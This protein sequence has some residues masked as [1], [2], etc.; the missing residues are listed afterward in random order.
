MAG[1]PRHSQCRRTS[2]R[3]GRWAGAAGPP[4]PTAGGD[5][6]EVPDVSADADPSSG[7]I[8]YD[9]VDLDD[10]GWTALGG[11]SGAAP[12]WA[13][14]LAVVASANGN[15]AGYGPLNPALYLLAQQSPG[16]LPQRRDGG[17]QR[18][19]RHVRRAVSRHARLRHGHRAGYAGGVGAGDRPRRLAAERGRLG[20]PDLRRIADLHRCRRFPRDRARCLSASR[21]TAAASTAP[22]W[23]HR[24]RS[25]PHWR[26][27]HT[28]SWRHRAAGCTLRGADA[29]DYAIV[30]T[31][32]A[33]DF[34]V[35]ADPGRR[36]SLG[37]PDL[38]GHAD[39]LG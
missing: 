30:Y 31:T 19:Q 36:R 29:S 22:P 17:E 14:V 15:T 27:A 12:L 21:S 24:R 10:G 34:T 20:Q 9:S 16:H 37:D 3:W 28:R 33:N 26:S 35:G 23:G 1:S 13:A 25:A 2:R 32:P 39:V 38:R 5:C 7:Y 6:R 8:I 18:L 11:T 4:A